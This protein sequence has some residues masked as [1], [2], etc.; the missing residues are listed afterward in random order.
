MIT[1]CM[2]WSLGFLGCTLKFLSTTILIQERINMVST[3]KQETISI[4]KH[5]YIEKKER[6]NKFRDIIHVL[7][8]AQL[9]HIILMASYKCKNLNDYQIIQNSWSSKW[10]DGSFFYI[11][12][13][14][15]HFYVQCEILWHTYFSIMNEFNFHLFWI[16]SFDLALR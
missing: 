16:I 6:F 3:Q 14:H 5:K 7:I 4:A 11:R 10:G 2:L 8:S 9:N 15:S 12:R 1:K 13:N